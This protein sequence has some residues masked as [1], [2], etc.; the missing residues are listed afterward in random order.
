VTVRKSKQKYIAPATGTSTSTPLTIS[1]I[2]SPPVNRARATKKNTHNKPAK[3]DL[4]N[5]IQD[6]FIPEIAAETDTS[7]DGTDSNNV[8]DNMVHPKKRVSSLFTV[9]SLECIYRSTGARETCDVCMSSVILTDD[10]FL[11][12]TN[13]K[14]SILYK[15]GSLDQTA[16]WRYYGADDNQTSDPTRCG[17]PV[18][19]LL[20]ESS[21]GCKVMCDG[22]GYSHDMLKIRRYT[23][24]QSMP[25]N[26]KSQYEVFQK[27]T[28]IAQNNGISKMIID[29]ALRFHKKI[30]ER[31]TFRGLNRDGIILAS[32]YIACRIH[33]CPRTVKEIASIFNLDNTSAT[34]G[35]K[36]AVAIINE[37]EC[38]L[39]NSEKTRFSRTKP[40]AF[41]DRYCSRLNVNN[42]LTKV[43]Q[44]IAHIIEKQN[45]IPENTPHSIAAG[46]VY[47]VA[48]VCN[49]NIT[50]KDVN[51]ISEISDVTI[52]KCFRKLYAIKDRL[53]PKIIM[54]KYGNGSSGTQVNDETN[55]PCAVVEDKEEPE[56]N[57]VERHIQRMQIHQSIPISVV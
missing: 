30:S 32:I 33:K 28:M 31:K 13:P 48:Q 16:E 44:F 34:K 27:I 9:Q 23:E 12:C 7:D 37:L 51:K 53:I 38:D 50:K 21:Y 10:G 43:C 54:D 11:T 55:N 39:D 14:C 49:L 46:I 18:N 57:K 40:E 2:V 35:C 24:W 4:W 45:L 3:V 56:R 42:E 52:N 19:P 47:F 8:L 22:G 25:Y 17:M 1:D 36:N 41:I 26:E 20:V 5:K 29:E 15:D 6:A